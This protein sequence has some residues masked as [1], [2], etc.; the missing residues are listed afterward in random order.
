ANGF[1]REREQDLRRRA[2]S[3]ADEV[4]NRGR[5]IAIDGLSPAERK[6]IH[7]TLADDPRVTS[8]SEGRGF[9]RQ[10]VIRQV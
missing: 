9:R 10:I 1:R 7:E 8:R 6:V 4:D 2:R 5:P 3:A